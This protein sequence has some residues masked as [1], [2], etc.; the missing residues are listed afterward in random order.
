MALTC[1]HHQYIMAIQ[2]LSRTVVQSHFIYFA[3]NDKLFDVLGQETIHVSKTREKSH[4]VF[5]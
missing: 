3:A 4:Y 1:N 2:Y 5:V